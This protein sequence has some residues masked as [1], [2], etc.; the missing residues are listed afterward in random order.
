VDRIKTGE[1]YETDGGVSG[2]MEISN[3]WGEVLQVIDDDNMLVIISNADEHVTVWCKFPTRDITDGKKDFLANII[4]ADKVTV[5]G[6]TRYRTPGGGTRTVFVLEPYGKQKKRSRVNDP[7]LK[8]TEDIG[9]GQDRPDLASRGSSVLPVVC[10]WGSAS[11]PP[12]G[13]VNMR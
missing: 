1:S 12:H 6:T 8:Q 13:V 3:T 10:G 2:R 11:S 5:T 9:H 7:A 4:R